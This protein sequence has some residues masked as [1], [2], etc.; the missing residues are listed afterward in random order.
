MPIQTQ[1]SVATK[2]LSTVSS[3]Q[4]DP[5]I[6]GTT[7][8]IFSRLARTNMSIIPPMEMLAKYQI[9]PP[10]GEI[11]GGG[12]EKASHD[13]LPCFGKLNTEDHVNH[14]T[15][16]KILENYTIISKEEL[17]DEHFSKEL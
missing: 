8:A 9:A 7:S 2:T 5:F 17:T 4:F 1:E 3:S 10:G 14:Y 15:F 13:C 16:N 11:S 6:H 12:L